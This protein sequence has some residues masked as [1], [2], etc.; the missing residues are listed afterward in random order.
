MRFHF[1]DTEI[2]Q[3]LASMVVLVDTREQNHEHIWRYFLQRDINFEEK[4]LD[5]ADYSCYLP[6]NED[7]GIMRPI[8]FTDSILI[9]RKGSLDELAGNLTKDRT[10]FESELLRAKGTN[11]ALMVENATYADVVMG[12]YRSEYK[13]KSFVAT[14]A[15][16]SA[17][18]GLDVNFVEKELA[19]N[20]IYYRLYYAVREELLHGC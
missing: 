18:Y 9:E 14:L 5:T 11:I 19:G 10:R 6:K 8:F 7:L 3:L 16:F 1:T 20:W 17:R 4:K 15:T 13:P 2:K 12:R